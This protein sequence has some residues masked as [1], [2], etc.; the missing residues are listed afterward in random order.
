L[1]QGWENLETGT[2]H[3][4]AVE[5]E[6]VSFRSCIY[7]AVLQLHNVYKRYNFDLGNKAF[8]EGYYRT[9]IWGFIHTL[10]NDMRFQYNTGEVTSSSSTTRKNA[11]RISTTKRSIQGRKFDGVI[12]EPSNKLELCTIEFGRVDGQNAIKSM[13]DRLKISKV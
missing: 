6:I 11:K 7:L 3:Q 5:N 9:F 12:S 13:N 1:S 2:I 4:S 8:G 10:L